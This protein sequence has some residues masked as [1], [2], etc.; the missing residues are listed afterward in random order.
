MGTKIQARAP[1]SYIVTQAMNK[2][3]LILMLYISH[4]INS[5]F[6]TSAAHVV[7]ALSVFPFFPL[8]F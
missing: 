2:L 7:N 6:H 3:M 8:H 1:T 5:C 4:E